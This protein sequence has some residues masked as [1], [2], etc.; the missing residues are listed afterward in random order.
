MWKGFTLCIQLRIWTQVTAA[1][2]QTDH[3]CAW[4]GCMAPEQM[5]YMVGLLYI[6]IV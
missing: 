3:G 1:A 5:Q 6:P 2:Y 4:A